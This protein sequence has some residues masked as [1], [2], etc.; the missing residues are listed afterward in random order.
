M[1]K[2][3]VI[4][5]AVILLASCAK[6]ETSNKDGFETDATENAGT[7]A[8]SADEYIENAYA[9]FENEDFDKAIVN[10]T[11]A[12]RL[13]PDSELL[14]YNRGIAYRNIDDYNKA[15]ADF[16]EAIM[17]NPNFVEAYIYRSTTYL[18]K[19][20]INKAIENYTEAIKQNPNVAGL[21]YNRGLTYLFDKNDYDNAIADFEAALKIEPDYKETIEQAKKA[22]RN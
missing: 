4:A 7:F 20:D 19:Q 18:E 21:Y 16:T 14:Y 1:K 17:L 9:Y 15:I 12:I 6:K 2:A 3:I 13:V 10:Y 11:E 5:L 8:Q 22:W